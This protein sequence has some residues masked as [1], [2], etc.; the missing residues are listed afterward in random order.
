MTLGDILTKY[1]GCKHPFLK[2]PIVVDQGIDWK[3][4]RYITRNGGKA[5]GELVGLIYDLEKLLPDLIDS[6]EIIEQLDQIVDGD[7]PY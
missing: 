6:N 1:F 5:Y 4:Y 3:H 2:H 7:S